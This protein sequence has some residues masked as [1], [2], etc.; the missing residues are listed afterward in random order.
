MKRAILSACVALF[1][2]VTLATSSLSGSSGH[3]S[4]TD[5]RVLAMR[6]NLAVVLVSAR[7]K[8]SGKQLDG[9]S[10][11]DFEVFDNGKL[12]SIRY[13]RQ[14]STTEPIALWLVVEC[15]QKSREEIAAAVSAR[16]LLE[17]ALKE[18]N[19]GDKIGVAH[20]CRHQ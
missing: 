6:V 1:V 10:A 4:S 18:L 17:P 14:E 2:V 15:S 9:L 19:S 3:F 7:D 13:F 20:F 16:E 11:D 5:N 12:A 8:E